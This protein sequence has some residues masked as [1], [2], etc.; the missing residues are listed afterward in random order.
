[1]LTHNS[2]T[3]CGHSFLETMLAL[4]LL[5]GATLTAGSEVTR[6]LFTLRAAQRSWHRGVSRGEV[7]LDQ[8]IPLSGEFRAVRC[9]T[10]GHSFDIE[11]P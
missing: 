9:T 2:G 8:C 7:P 5:A 4:T 6:S 11:L 10:P 1:M 3:E